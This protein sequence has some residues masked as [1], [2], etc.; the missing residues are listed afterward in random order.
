MARFLILPVFL[1]VYASASALFA[2]NIL[3]F[4]KN[5][6]RQAFYKTG[7]VISFR[8]KGDKSKHKG[9]I[10]NIEDSVIVIRYYRIDPREISDLYVDDKTKIWFILRYKYG[11]VLPMAG[12]GYLLLDAINTGEIKEETLVISASLIAT[13]ILLKS[14]IGKRLRVRGKRKL[15]ILHH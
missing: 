13:G 8:L 3:M 6:Y 9:Q 15:Q 7:D 2:Q 1:Y 4:Q 12:V 11:K 14:I 5:R 10:K